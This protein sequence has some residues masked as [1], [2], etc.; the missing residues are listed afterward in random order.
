VA[1]T[2]V[3]FCLAG[4]CIA[5]AAQAPPAHD[6]YGPNRV[7]V[8]HRIVGKPARFVDRVVARPSLATHL[9]HGDTVGT[10]VYGS[11]SRA[12]AV[13]LLT[14][15]GVPVVRVVAGR[16]YSIVVRDPSQTENFHLSGPSGSRTTTRRFVG[17]VRW[18]M[19][20]AKGSYRYRSDAHPALRRFVRAR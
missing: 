18:K 5:T 3:A 17:T 19:T 8:C 12:G 14:G 4:A 1:T 2:T 11:V 6:Q 9:R 15:K 13:S 16:P 10:C 20:F 7:Q